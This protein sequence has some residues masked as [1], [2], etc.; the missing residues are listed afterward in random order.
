M[1][2]KVINWI[3]E[4]QDTL[5][6][7]DLDKIKMLVGGICIE[8]KAHLQSTTDAAND[9]AISSQKLTVDVSR[10]I[11]EI[12]MHNWKCWKCDK[13]YD[14]ETE[15]GKYLQNCPHCKADLVPF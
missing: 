9:A 10:L 14:L 6:S 7:S 2:T 11:S 1:N 8:M 4:I 3:N 12:D 13:V 5:K 15:P